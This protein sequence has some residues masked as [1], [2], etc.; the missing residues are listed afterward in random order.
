MLD[1]PAIS[2]STGFEGTILIIRATL[3]K[4]MIGLWFIQDHLI[5]SPKPMRRKE[6]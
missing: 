2:W 1:I 5:Q 4:L 3:G 6:R